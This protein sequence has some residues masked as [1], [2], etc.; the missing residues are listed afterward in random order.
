MRVESSFMGCQQG[1]GVLEDPG[2]LSSLSPCDCLSI[3]G[4]NC[5][6]EKLGNLGLGEFQVFSI[7]AIPGS[8]CLLSGWLGHHYCFCLTQG[9]FGPL[10][11]PGSK[12]LVRVP[13][14]TVAATD[15]WSPCLPDFLLLVLVHGQ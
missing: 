11:H 12:L 8:S 5:H 4:V 13:D 15:H 9:Q 10:E 14:I 2:P 6:H 7:A 1:L 3:S